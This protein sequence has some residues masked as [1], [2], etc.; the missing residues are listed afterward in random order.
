MLHQ[1]LYLR[2]QTIRHHLL[3]ALIDALVQP[4]AIQTQDPL[5]ARDFAVLDYQTALASDSAAYGKLAQPQS[6]NHPPCIVQMKPMRQQW[7]DL[8]QTLFERFG[9]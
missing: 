4:T 9:P 3:D 6:T 2:L 8:R 7:I 1:P 5:T